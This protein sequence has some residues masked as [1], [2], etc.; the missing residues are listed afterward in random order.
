MALSKDARIVLGAA[1]PASPPTAREVIGYAETRSR[2]TR[3]PKTIEVTGAIPRS[4]ATK[5]N[6]GR[7]VEE[8]G[9]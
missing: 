9:G 6:R 2:P 1:D 5:A 8:R 3:C 4:E 7:L